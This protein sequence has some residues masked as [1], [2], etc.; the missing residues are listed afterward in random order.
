MRWLTDSDSIAGSLQSAGT[1]DLETVHARFDFDS[2]LF[3][4][5]A[6]QVASRSNMIDALTGSRRKG[7]SHSTNIT[8][9]PLGDTSGP[10]RSS[11][12]PRTGIA[13]TTVVDVVSDAASDSLDVPALSQAAITEPQTSP[14]S[15]IRTRDSEVQLPDYVIHPPE[16]LGLLALQLGEPPSSLAPNTRIQIRGGLFKVST[17]LPLLFRPKN[18]SRTS[19][20]VA[21]IPVHKLV[22]I[23][24]LGISESGKTTL[25]K[26][27]RAGHGDID[28]AWLRLYRGTILNNTILSLKWLLFM[29]YRMMH[30]GA[31][32]WPLEKLWD[33]EAYFANARVIWE[34]EVDGFP[35]SSALTTIASAAQY[36]WS[37]PYIRQVLKTS[38]TAQR[39]ITSGKH[40][41]L[42]LYLPDCAE[43]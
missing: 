3:N 2:E 14:T 32:L 42:P 22:R 30:D 35:K 4:S 25:A 36:L 18:R 34:L 11:E 20:P 27:M 24:I 16:K 17:R 21:N 1:Q 9:D 29:A 23:L 7:I 38:R 33:E 15:L 26:T 31:L 41:D 12:F 28:K 10:K 43:Q 5:R 8:S 40:L 19:F 6:Y 39:P 37:H 13:L